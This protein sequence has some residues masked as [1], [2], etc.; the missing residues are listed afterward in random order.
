[1]SGSGFAG[2]DCSTAVLPGPSALISVVRHQPPSFTAV[3]DTPGMI[4][5]NVGR[6][7]PGQQEC[8]F[9]RIAILLRQ[10]HPFRAE[11]FVG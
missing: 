1:V 4:M 10:V 6:G 3:D 9:S 11:Y 5:A 2:P 8:D 7:A